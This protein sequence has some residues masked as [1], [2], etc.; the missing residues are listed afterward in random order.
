MLLVYVLYTGQAFLS[1]L[2]PQ[3][4]VYY[5]IVTACWLGLFTLLLSRRGP[6]WQRF[7]QHV[8]HRV[9][10][11]LPAWLRRYVTDRRLIALAFAAIGVI[12]VVSAARQIA[13]VPI[14]LQNT[15]DML[16][17]IQR[18]VT[19]FLHGVNPY[20]G[21]RI[22]LE[23]HLTYLPGLWMTYIPAELA[24]VDYRWTGVVA[25]L[26]IL[27]VLWRWCE[28]IR[29]GLADRPEELRVV[30]TIQSLA[31]TALFFLSAGQRWF[32]PLMHTPPWWLWLSLFAYWAATGREERASLMLGLCC[33]SRQTAF[34]LLPIW[35]IYLWTRR[36][37]R[38]PT[39]LTLYA[40]PL[41]VLLLPFFLW[42]P[43]EFLFGTVSWYRISSALSWGFLAE[44]NARTFGLTSILYALGLLRYS[45][46]AQVAGLAVIFASAAR[47]VSDVADVF[48]W[49]CWALL[50][51]SMT[52]Y[53]PYAYLYLPVFLLAS[54][55]LLDA[56][57]RGSR[58][59][60]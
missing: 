22:A 49:M 56:W 26:A 35:L 51:F 33:A 55:T 34:V 12:F 6:R 13:S 41:V 21:Y 23:V 50:W 32:V 54:I 20:R 60:V 38:L 25:D 46:V 5:W 19:N 44:S 58:A 48:R 29:E 15:G 3:E 27:A 40:A 30:F 1:P 18:A 2:L 17:L 10:D 47:T 52:S 43:R 16:P 45:V 59:H 39:H 7:E 8:E 31:L 42:N 24:K 53:V 9:Y 57:E 36:R 4:R 28:R 37:D 14:A 11:L